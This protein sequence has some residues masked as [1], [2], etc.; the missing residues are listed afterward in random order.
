M[1]IQIHNIISE[2]VQDISVCMRVGVR[3]LVLQYGNQSITLSNVNN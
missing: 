2:S 1:D 3:F